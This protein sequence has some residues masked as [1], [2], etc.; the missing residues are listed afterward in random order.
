MTEKYKAAN[1]EQKRPY[2]YYEIIMKIYRHETGII[3][4]GERNLL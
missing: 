4:A 2:N 1:P 3:F